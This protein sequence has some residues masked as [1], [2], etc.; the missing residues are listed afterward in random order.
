MDDTT[1][2]ELKD[3]IANCT[4][5]RLDLIRRY[6]GVRPSWVSTDVAILGDRIDKYK[7]MLAAME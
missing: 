1:A 7:E 6:S 3:I 4:K 2:E 5:E